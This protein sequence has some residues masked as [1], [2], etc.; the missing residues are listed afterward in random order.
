MKQSEFSWIDR[1]LKPLAFYPGS[2]N[3]QDD[4]AYI[5]VSEQAA[6]VVSTDAAVAGIHFEPTADPNLIARK[7]L[8]AAVS[9]L[10]AKGAMPFGYF[11]NMFLSE[12]TLAESWL[13]AFTRGL[14]DVQQQYKMT[15]LGG[16]TV[17]TKQNFAVDYTVLG[18]AEQGGM[19][20]RNTAKDG[21][22]LY[23]TGTLGDSY[24]GLQCLLEQMHLSSADRDWVL[25]RHFVPEL[26]FELMQK[27]RHFWT[28]SIDISD[29]FLADL[30]HIL[31]ASNQSA[32]V[33]FDAL[34]FSEIG[35]S[36]L[37]E[38]ANAIWK[39]LTGGEDY[40]LILTI[41]KDKK[42]AFEACAATTNTRVSHVGHLVSKREALL[43]NP[44][45]ATIV[46]PE[47]LGFQHF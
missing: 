5:A 8:L 43:Y 22:L 35:K 19:V 14:S 1:Y 45:G 7:T 15:I 13:Q 18:W 32:I 47:K 38:D 21:D 26:R 44:E 46:L 37:N 36:F 28:S 42:G 12:E 29:G 3:L 31:Q 20:Q 33:D 30:K 9:D 23:V 4:A 10:I 11:M 16:D 2:F 27:T 24:L 17:C 34:P 6:L 40:E 39:L 41:E 25:Q